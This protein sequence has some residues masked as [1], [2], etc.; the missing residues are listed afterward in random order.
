MPRGE[1]H[2]GGKEQVTY[3]YAKFYSTSEISCHLENIFKTLE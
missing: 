2:Q 3:A 1:P